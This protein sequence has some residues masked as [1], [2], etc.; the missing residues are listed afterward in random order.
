MGTNNR[1][2]VL[3]RT[4]FNNV[5]NKTNQKIYLIKE[6]NQ[7]QE[8]SDVK[9]INEY[10]IVNLRKTNGEFIKTVRL[11]TK[12]EWNI[13]FFLTITLTNYVRHLTYITN[14]RNENNV[15]LENMVLDKF[16]DI[17][18]HGETKN[19]EMKY[20]PEMMLTVDANDV[21][22]YSFITGEEFYVISDE[23]LW[24]EMTEISY[25]RA[26]FNDS[27]ITNTMVNGRHKYAFNIVLHNVEH[28]PGGTQT[29]TG[30][31]I[32]YKDSLKRRIIERMILNI[33]VHS[34]SVNGDE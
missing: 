28:V 2:E 17:K 19:I 32:I 5:I 12:E 30:R 31:L 7:T 21:V 15:L 22:T 9:Y 6:D 10:K 20:I 4:A 14:W 23:E 27:G 26:T 8:I 33:K 25:H 13:P 11:D 29:V 1:V 34:T 16:N 3:T 24:F 18:I